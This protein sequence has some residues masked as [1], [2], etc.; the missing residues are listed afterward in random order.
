MNSG[1]VG[2]MGK[3]R[4]FGKSVAFLLIVIYFDT[5]G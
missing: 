4:D 3:E 1:T 2:H 5:V